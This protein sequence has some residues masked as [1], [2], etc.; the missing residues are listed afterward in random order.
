MRTWAGIVQQLVGQLLQLMGLAGWGICARGACT[1]SPSITS[2][3]SIEQIKR[4]LAGSDTF[5]KNHSQ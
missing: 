3:H 4:E 2:L 1:N 5:T